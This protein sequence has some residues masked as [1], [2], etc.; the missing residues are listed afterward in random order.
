[1]NMPERGLRLQGPALLRLGALAERAQRPRATPR[2][3]A[4]LA[5]AVSALA[6]ERS[7]SSSKAE[8][9]PM[10][11]K[12][13]VLASAAIA[14][15]A[16]ATDRLVPQQ[17]PTIQAAVD[18]SVHGDRVVISPGTYTQPIV[19][20]GRSLTIEGVRDATGQR[21][22][23]DGLAQHRIM[24]ITN[25]DVTIRDLEFRMGRAVTLPR[26]DGA[27]IL[28]EGA[29]ALAVQRCHFESCIAST[30][31]TEQGGGGAIFSWEDA[32]TATDCTFRG[33]Q[34][35]RGS[36]VF[37]VHRL[38][39]CVIESG[40]DTGGGVFS[41]SIGQLIE[42]CTLVNTVVYMVA[43]DLRMSGTWNCGLSKFAFEVSGQ[44]VDLG[45]N[46]RAS[47]CDCDQ[48][49]VLD[50]IQ[51]ANPSVDRNNDGIIDSC[52]CIADI[53]GNGSVD[54]VDLA[55]VLGSWGSGGGGKPGADIDGDGI[56]AG[57]DLAIVLG[58][59]GACP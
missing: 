10:K 50:Y 48:D 8:E 56:V 7:L 2:F 21:P 29:G 57:T 6:A 33:N 28:R 53:T 18:A 55:A 42:D 49:A 59:W 19:I 15:S 11:S 35:F 45:G 1:M 24:A 54:G 9:N 26:R 38:I 40:A 41:T 12:L 52:Q 13:S 25:S 44:L 31:S 30:S 34:A 17:Y 16:F 36:A 27:G 14:S 37:G 43:A 32:V 47:E 22:I 4:I 58:S 23:L 5:V 20:T 51:L 3:L 46:R 39:R